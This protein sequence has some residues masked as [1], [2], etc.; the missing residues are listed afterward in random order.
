MPTYYISFKMKGFIMK[1]IQRFCACFFVSSIVVIC[2]VILFP[3]IT[4]AEEITEETAMDTEQ[5]ERLN[6]LEIRLE[7]LGYQINEI[8]GTLEEVQ[9]SELSEQEERLLISEKL[10]LVIVAL[11]DLINYD[12][13]ILTKADNSE[14]LVTEYRVQVLDSFKQLNETTLQLSA[15][16]VSG[17][18]LVSQLD[19]TVAKGNS[20][21]LEINA[22]NDEI[23]NTRFLAIIGVIG[24]AIGAIF[25]VIFSTWFK[26][27]K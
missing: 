15:D 16:T 27:R 19:D 25:G 10:D 8:T 3:F 26:G 21:V 7:E 14:N 13:E 11:N 17:N 12:I 4:H 20:D 9:T 23:A 6:S 5:N 18:T 24:I 22:Q 2:L 1:T